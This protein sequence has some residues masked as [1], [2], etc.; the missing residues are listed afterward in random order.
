MRLSDCVLW[1]LFQ[2]RFSLVGRAAVTPTAAVAP[3]GHVHVRQ[4]DYNNNNTYNIVMAI[5]IFFNLC[6]G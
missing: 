3:I 4:Y 6:D 2:T 5:V 1:S